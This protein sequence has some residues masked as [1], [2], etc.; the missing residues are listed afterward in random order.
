VTIDL[1]FNW[2]SL[3]YDTRWCK[4]SAR[5]RFSWQ[6]GGRELVSPNL[7]NEIAY[8]DKDYEFPFPNW[9]ITFGNVGIKGATISFSIDWRPW[10]EANPPA[11]YT[12][13]LVNALTGQVFSESGPTLPDSDGRAVHVVSAD[14]PNLTMFKVEGFAD[15]NWAYAQDGVVIGM[16]NIL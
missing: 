4:D 10:D 2:T 14:I 5:G 8:T 16:E 1:G 7:W 13:R 9:V 11:S 12:S 3:L 6:K 15:G